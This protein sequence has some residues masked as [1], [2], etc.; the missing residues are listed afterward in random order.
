MASKYAR[1]FNVP[2]GFAEVLKDFTRE[3]LRSQA[4]NIYQFGYEYFSEA[5][6]R[7]ENPDADGEMPSMRLNREELKAK[8]EQLFKD[9]D[10]DGNGV[11]DRNEFKQ[12]FEGLTSELNLTKKDIM[13]II[14]EADENDDGFIEY[15]E[16]APVAVDV[17]D[18][19]YAKQDYEMEKQLRKEDA[20]ED[21]REF[22][23][24][25]MPR[26]ELEA[27]LGD[28]FVKADEDQNG[29]LSRKEFV[30]CIKE[31]DL[32]FTRKE[33]NVLLSEVDIDHDGKISYEEFVPLCFTLL[34]EMVSESLIE[35]PQEEEELAAFFLDLFGSAANDE[36]LLSHRDALSLLKQAD[37]GL[38]RIQMHAIMSEANETEGMLKYDELAKAVAGMAIT[39]VNLEMQADRAEKTAAHRAS[40]NYGTVLGMDQTTMEDALFNAFQS[41]AG[42]GS[43]MLSLEQLDAGISSAL[44]GVSSKQKNGILSVAHDYLG[45]DGLAPYEVVVQSAYSILLWL[46]E[47]EQISNM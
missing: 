2:D 23:L 22:L 17:V 45:E 44:P 20:L 4:P 5:M 8:I 3:V 12:V 32:G 1:Q 24:H 39:L 36:G 28:V 38:T 43:Q 25:G 40:D 16:F 29:W 33:V 19:I 42:D 35:A 47:Q 9:A 11:L 34:V 37:L 14:A 26:E 30:K 46:L 41:I 31:A 7:R 6:A 10:A 13:K 21:A 18:S 27:M 15:A